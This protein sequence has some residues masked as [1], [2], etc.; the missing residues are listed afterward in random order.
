MPVAVISNHCSDLHARI[1]SDLYGR[2]TSVNSMWG[3]PAAR[4]K[5]AQATPHTNHCHPP[6][7]I[8]ASRGPIQI[9]GGTCPARHPARPS[10]SHC[11]GSHTNH[12]QPPIQ[13]TA[14]LPY[15]SLPL[16]HT[17]HCHSPTQI[18]ASQPRTQMSNHS[19]PPIQTTLLQ[20]YWGSVSTNFVWAIQGRPCTRFVPFFR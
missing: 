6:I 19:H 7:Q 20:V 9:T 11:A 16:S 8:T 10:R 13:I 15:K 17:N 12:C 2:L 4:N 14:S 1:G 5:L 18:T 3:H